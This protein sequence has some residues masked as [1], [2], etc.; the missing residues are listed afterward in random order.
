MWWH[1]TREHRRPLWGLWYSRDQ[2]LSFDFQFFDATQGLLCFID[3]L[4][5]NKKH[6]LCTFFSCFFL[7][8]FNNKLLQNNFLQFN[9]IPNCRQKTSL[10]WTT[11]K[12]LINKDYHLPLSTPIKSKLK[13]SNER[14]WYGYLLWCIYK[15]FH[16]TAKR[17]TK[18]YVKPHFIVN[19]DVI[20]TSQ[21]VSIF[22]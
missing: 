7:A 8:Y 9:W 13:N 21:Q 19:Q 14:I 15:V 18:F 12:C 6:A 20:D 1:H 3:L 4:I 16:W 2:K 10:K 22:L 11:S 17:N 5:L